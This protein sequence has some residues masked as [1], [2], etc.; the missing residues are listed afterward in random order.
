MFIRVTNSNDMIAYAVALCD[1]DRFDNTLN[2]FPKKTAAIQRVVGIQTETLNALQKQ[3]DS[4]NNDNSLYSTIT[5]MLNHKANS[6]E[7]HTKT[8]IQQFFKNLI[9]KAPTTALAYDANNA[10]TAH[11]QLALTTYK[12]VDNYLPLQPPKLAST[13]DLRAGKRI[14]MYFEPR[15]PTTVLLLKA[16]GNLLQHTCFQN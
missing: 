6:C 2:Q 7:V 16:D 14:T 9:D 8:Q 15:S 11:S 12:K 3:A 10:A 4:I 5:G 13:T 1:D